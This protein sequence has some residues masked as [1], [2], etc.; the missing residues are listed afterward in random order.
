MALNILKILES[1]SKY[2]RESL[3]LAIFIILII[4]LFCITIV[5]IAQIFKKSNQCTH[6][7]KN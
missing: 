6:I 2:P 1:I 5:E 3:S 4:F 7:D